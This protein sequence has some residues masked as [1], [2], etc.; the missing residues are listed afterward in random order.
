[1]D[2]ALLICNQRKAQATAKKQL[3][4]LDRTRS[5]RVLQSELRS[6]TY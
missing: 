5:N 2:L 4:K 3:R 1:M 6:V